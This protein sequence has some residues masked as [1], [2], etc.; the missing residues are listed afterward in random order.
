MAANLHD[1]EG[2]GKW[3]TMYSEMAQAVS[4]NFLASSIFSSAFLVSFCLCILSHPSS[5]L[6]LFW[7]R[8]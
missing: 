1:A 4:L 2:V 3:E 7:A 6:E 8:G 5:S